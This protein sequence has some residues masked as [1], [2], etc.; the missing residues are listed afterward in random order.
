MHQSQPTPAPFVPVHGPAESRLLVLG[1][2]G[3]VGSHVLEAAASAGLV[4]LGAGRHPGPGEIACDLLEPESIVA[5][6]EAA[7]PDTILN[8]AGSASVAA[9]WRDPA[10][11]FDAN[12]LGALNL[13]EAV[14]EHR[15]GTHLTCVSSGEVYGEPADP[16][17]LPF[18]EDRPPAPV[19][20]YG[21]S[22]QAMEVLAGQYARTHGLQIAVVRLFNQI[23]PGQ[24]ERFAASGFARQIVAA[25]LEGAPS[26]EL[27]VGNIDARRDFTDVR[28]TARAFARVSAERLTGVFNLCSG[29]PHSLRDLIEAMAKETPLEVSTVV[30][31]ELRRPTDQA[32]VFGDPTLLRET[33]GWEPGILLQRT[34]GDI[35]QRWRERLA[36][37]A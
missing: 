18:R 29:R 8:L 2:S 31:E 16:G 28:D 22:K 3:F 32:L 25:E 12:A 30:D 33:I 26:A 19:N 24:A 20:P 35:L 9:S 13:L 4:A 21:V 11:A 36:G 5:C 6:L 7:A 10:A 23:G 1:S 17:D 27:R 14:A 37:A 34:V 15:P